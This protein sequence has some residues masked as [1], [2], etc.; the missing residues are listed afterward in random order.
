MNVALV[1]HMMVSGEAADKALARAMEASQRAIEIAP[2]SSQAHLMR[3]VTLFQVGQ[4][5]GFVAE[6]SLAQKLNPASIQ[7]L[8]VTGNRL[9]QMGRYAE[10][11]AL[12]DKAY[13]INPTFPNVNKIMFLLELYRRGQYNEAIRRDAEGEWDKRQYSAPMFMTAIY[14]EMGETEKAKAELANLTTLWPTV[15]A[16]IRTWL[17][18]NHFTDEISEKLVDG[19]VKAGLEVT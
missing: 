9:Y 19:L 15:G 3:A 18:I 12:I 6:S 2:D 14:G 13:K 16:N 5:D 4:L 10:G 8:F 11:L 17:K 1:R 7:P